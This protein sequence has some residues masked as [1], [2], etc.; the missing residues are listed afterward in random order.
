VTRR[1]QEII[2]RLWREWCRVW[3]EQYGHGS[4]QVKLKGY[5]PVL[6]LIPAQTYKD[7]FFEVVR[8]H[9]KLRH[10][11]VFE[12]VDV[13]LNQTQAPE[14]P[15][16]A[17]PASVELDEEIIGLPEVE[18]SEIEIDEVAMEDTAQNIEPFVVEVELMPVYEP[19]DPQRQVDIG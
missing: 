3:P 1:E 4:L 2:L 12:I 11:N 6:D 7:F 8:G 10:L 13:A 14:T 18:E 15:V 9:P 19:N 5:D 17:R 16:F